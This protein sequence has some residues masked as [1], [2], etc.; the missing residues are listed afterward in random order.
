MQRPK[1]INAWSRISIISI[2]SIIQQ[3]FIATLPFTAVDSRAAARCSTIL[4]TERI[5]QFVSTILC[6]D[7][8]YYDDKWLKASPGSLRTPP[9]AGLAM[10]GTE[11]KNS[12]S[13][14][15][16]SLC[17]QFWK[18]FF[19]NIICQVRCHSNESMCLQRLI[20][21]ICGHRWNNP[22]WN[23]LTWDSESMWWLGSDALERDNGY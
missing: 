2:I 11:I 23:W 3:C 17:S 13:L 20:Y 10:C 1:T 22:G 4:L 7:R 18:G 9:T 15:L 19:V 21:S 6:L 16:H 8:T 12:P 14:N 5:H